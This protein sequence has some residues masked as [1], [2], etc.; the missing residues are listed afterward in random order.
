MNRNIFKYLRKKII[1]NSIITEEKDDDSRLFKIECLGF[2]AIV[3]FP[4]EFNPKKVVKGMLVDRLVENK[5]FMKK[6]EQFE[7][8]QNNLKDLLD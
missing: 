4:I 3:G 8:R 7:N 1:S 6:F 5:D 2:I